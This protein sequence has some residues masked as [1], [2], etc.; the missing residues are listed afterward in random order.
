[1]LPITQIQEIVQTQ[2]SEIIQEQNDDKQT[3]STRNLSS[4]ARAQLLLE[5][6]NI[7]FDHKL[8]VFTVKGV[9]GVPR[10]VTL[11]PKQTCSCPSTGEC[12]HILAIQMSLGKEIESKPSRKNLTQL[13]RNTRKKV[14][15]KSG[16]KRPRPGDI[17]E[18]KQNK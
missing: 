1:M 15:K 2:E 8:H 18:G 3:V 17:N 9:S 7:S 14:D 6:G 13:R 12:Y 11:F 5:S 4:R 16:R 10:V